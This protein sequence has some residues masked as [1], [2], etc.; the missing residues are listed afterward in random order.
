MLATHTYFQHWLCPES[1]TAEGKEG[2]PPSEQSRILHVFSTSDIS[3]VLFPCTQQSL[4]AST[5]AGFSIYFLV[6]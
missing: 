1:L 6:Y 2:G 5:L 4:S 3:D